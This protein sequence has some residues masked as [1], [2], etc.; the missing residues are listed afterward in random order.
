MNMR[1]KEETIEQIRHQFVSL[2]GV[3][4]ER[5]RRQWA[6]TEVE[7]YGRGGLQW[8]CEATGMS[9][10]TIARGIKEIKER[11]QLPVEEQSIS[12]RIRQKGGG[13]KLL[14]E[15]DRELLPSLRRIVEPGRPH[16]AV[17][18]DYYECLYDSGRTDER[19][20]SGK[21]PHGGQYVKS[22]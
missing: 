4:D 6:A 19:R 8:V 5:S 15:K 21:P 3:L 17:M 1:S 7:K 13:R 9:H 2:T 22:R 10:N 12:G 18:L 20:A 16:E 14:E 11:R